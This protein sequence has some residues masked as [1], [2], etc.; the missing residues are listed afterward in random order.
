MCERGVKKRRANPSTSCVSDQVTDNLLGFD[1]SAILEIPVHD[2]VMVDP[3]SVNR[4][5]VL[6]R[7]TSL[8]ILPT[9]DGLISWSRCGFICISRAG[10]AQSYRI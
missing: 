2:D 10:E 1:G 3:F 4:A 5:R 9:A 6:V 8:D 7:N